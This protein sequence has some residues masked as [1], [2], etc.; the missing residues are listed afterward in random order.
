MTASNILSTLI[1]TGVA[2][3]AATATY[4]LI[5]VFAQKFFSSSISHIIGYL[6]A[7]SGQFIM[8]SYWAFFE[9]SVDHLSRL[10]RFM[11]Q[12]AA[13]IT[14]TYFLEGVI[15]SD[16]FIEATL[17]ITVITSLNLL[18]YILFTFKR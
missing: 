3:I 1:K 12:C 5:F 15:Q 11:V 2:A 16:D 10:L 17:L 9:K 6:F 18:F 7:V 8:L 13:I 14:V 4:F